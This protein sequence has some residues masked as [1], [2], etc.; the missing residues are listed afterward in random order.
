MHSSSLTAP[1]A[2]LKPAIALQRDAGL[3]TV[4]DGEMRGSAWHMDFIYQLEGVAQAQDTMHLAF[5]NAKRSLDYQPPAIRVGG[6][7]ALG[8]PIFADHFSFLR[9]HA[10]EGQVPKLTILSPSMVHCWGG[11]AT[12]DPAAYPNIGAFWDD[13]VEAYRAEIA[14]V[15]ALGCRYLQLDDTSLA[16]STTPLN[17]EH[18]R[19][20]GG[21]P[22]HLHEQYI[23]TINAALAAPPGRPGRHHTPVPR[24]QPADVDGRGR[25][26][27]RGR[28][29]VRRAGRRRLL[30]GV[31][32]QALRRLRAAA[33]VTPGKLVVLGLVTTKRRQLEAP[34]DLKRRIDE[35]AQVVDVDQLCLSGQC[36]FSSTE[37]GN[38]LTIEEEIAKL[39]LVVEVAQDVWN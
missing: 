3:V 18:I 20:I 27:V 8:E 33:F 6:R 5:L 29:A 26:R 38:D 23:A 19:S 21:D 32:R 9:D 7:V 14:A 4:T 39:R 17:T 37:A 10:L 1:L 22:A 13:L 2:R 28:G 16:F 15:Y 35:A 34:D 31:R 11:N 24:E 36:R 25:L 12:I 30:P